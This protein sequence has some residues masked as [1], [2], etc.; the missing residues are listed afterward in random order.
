M[1][2]GDRDEQA[3]TNNRE[4]VYHYI[5]TYPGSH[6]RKIS[7][8]LSLGMG[9]TQHHLNFLEKAGSV[10]SRRMSIYKVYYAAS[11]LEERQESILAI[12]RLETPRSILL[13]LIENPGASQGEIAK[14]LGFASPT[15]NWHTSRLI[16]IGLVH[17]RKDG[18][19]VKYNIEGD[20][21]EITALLKSFYP[22]IWDKLSNRLVDLFLDISATR[23][24]EDKGDDYV[25]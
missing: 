4:L 14:H 13:Y 20:L 8:E 11:I 5:E 21:K 25:E 16:E 10:R 6:L 18:R 3:I 23:L 12:L 2:N 9:D 15:I 22:T 24:P 19:F 7:K 1:Y 17:S